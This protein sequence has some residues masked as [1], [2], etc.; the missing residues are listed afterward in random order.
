MRFEDW[1]RS[2]EKDHGA[3]SLWRMKAYRLS[4]FLSELVDGDAQL[5]RGHVVASA[6]LPQLALAVAS[7]GA[8]IAEGYS[9]STGRD[10]ARFFEYALGS[11]RDARHFYRAGRGSLSMTILTA[12]LEVLEEVI[13]LLIATVRYQRQSPA[14]VRLP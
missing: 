1:E 3:D 4:M 14:S 7:I 5:M 9:R 2:V 11:A 13:R 6:I 10:R 12:R 8:N